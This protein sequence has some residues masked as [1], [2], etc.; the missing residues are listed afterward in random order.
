M[1][2]DAVAHDTRPVNGKLNGNKPVD[3]DFIRK[4]IDKS[5]LNA[6]RLALLQVTGDPRLAK[7]STRRR[8]IRGGAMFSHVLSDED[9]PLLKEIAFNYLSQRKSDD[10]VPPP[11][12]KEET[13]KLLDMFG[14]ESIQDVEFNYN[15]EELAFE[16]FPRNAK[17]SDKEPSAEAIVDFKIVVIGAG[18]SGLAAAVQ[19]KNLG[20]NF[21][22]L[23]RQQ[24]I[25]GTWL[26]NTYPDARVDTSSY[27]FQFK[28]LKNYPWSEYFAR[29][30]ETRGYLE[31]VAEKYKVKDH[32]HFNREVIRAVWDEDTSKWDL[33][34]RHSNGEVENIKCNAIVSGSGLFATPNLPDFPGLKDFKGPVF[35]TAKWDHSV[36][37]RNKRV[38]LIGT[39]ST[40]TQLAS[41]VASEAKDFTVF[42]RTPNWIMHMDGYGA[43]IDDEVRFIFNK[44]PYYWNW[45]C[46]S[47]HVASQQLQYMQTYDQEWRAK[48]GIVNERNDLARKNLTEYIKSKSEGIPGLLEKILPDYPPLVRRLVVDNGFY[49]MLRRDN[50]KLAAEDID[51]FTEDGIV[52]ASG[53]EHEFDVVIL[54]TGFKVSDYFWPC[55][56]IGRDGTTLQ[57]LWSKDGPRSY[58]GLTM[59][60]FP[61]FFSLYGP[62]HQPRSGGFYSWGEIWSRYVASS[63]VH[64]IENG[65]KSIECRKDVFDEYNAKLDEKAKELIWEMEGSGYYVNR[66][67]RQSVNAPWFTYDYHSM[68][69]KPNFDDF[70][71]R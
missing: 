8:A 2:R 70:E 14:D 35:H 34:V 66:F 9:A 26:L 19:F 51:R 22:V 59:P 43:K 11:P 71:V 64:L 61:N 60:G 36:D 69:M 29:A 45:F 30:G 17:W 41:R 58:L 47:A 53:E 16:E 46:Y 10:A 6:L 40:G 24:G 62:N 32:F 13:R 42:Q 18:I 50:V 52:S 65:R 23:E 28:F 20:L 49:D 37:Y 48:G 56:Y 21:E 54:G 63:I 3:D 12:S 68:V 27:L 1:A 55:K 31:Y 25:G 67:G 38:A 4:A 33:T 44:M 7:M 57:D 39:G 15:Y 5:N